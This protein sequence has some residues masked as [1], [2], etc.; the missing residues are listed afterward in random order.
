MPRRLPLIPLALAALFLIPACGRDEGFRFRVH[1][2][3]GEIRFKNQPVPNA[4]VRF[5]P[6]DPATVQVP[7]GQEG[8]PVLL[9]TATDE[10]GKFS[11]STYFADDGVPAGDYN[12]VVLPGTGAQEDV[13]SSDGPRRSAKPSPADRLIPPKYRKPETTTL[14]AT[15]KPGEENHFVFD[16]D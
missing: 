14:K 13:E 7:D 2:A 10:Q 5:Q 12:V 1:P 11:M 15:V 16:L 9:T 6:V 3:S 8:L 4:F